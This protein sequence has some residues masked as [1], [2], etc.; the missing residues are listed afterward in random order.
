MQGRNRK[1]ARTGAEYRMTQQCLGNHAT[2]LVFVLSAP[3]GTG[4]TT[5]VRKLCR[6]FS[7]VKASVSYTTRDP[8]IGE[9]QGRDYFFV[10]QEEF[11]RSISLGEFLE[12]AEVF[13]RHYG[14]KKAE[15]EEDIQKGF[16]VILVI[17]TQGALCLQKQGFKA[18]YIFLAPPTIQALE[19]RL[20]L[21]KTESASKR[22]ERL[23]WAKREMEQSHF[24]DYLVVNDKIEVA[25]DVLKSILIAEEHRIIKFK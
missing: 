11:C 4:K 12:H 22:A 9:I 19:D 18:V 16:H 20:I 25:Y 13:G 17:D 15:I 14:T 24:Y 1:N 5:L 7:C 2:G 6:K 21:R 8:R 3:A 23:S 10:S